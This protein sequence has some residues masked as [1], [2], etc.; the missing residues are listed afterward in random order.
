MGTRRE[1][2]QLTD[3]A[4]CGMIFQR[5]VSHLC[6]L[7]KLPAVET[8]RAFLSLEMLVTFPA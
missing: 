2:Q 5:E 4:S 7:K 6:R 8:G 3:C 1:S